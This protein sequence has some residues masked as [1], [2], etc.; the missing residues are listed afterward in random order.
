MSSLQARPPPAQ[1]FASK[2]LLSN[3]E[4]GSAST[5]ALVHRTATVKAT[6]LPAVMAEASPSVPART[7]AAAAEVIALRAVPVLDFARSAQAHLC[8][9]V[10]E[11]PPASMT[12]GESTAVGR[13]PV[14]VNLATWL[15]LFVPAPSMASSSVATASAAS[16]TTSQP[17]L[18]PSSSWPPPSLGLYQ[19]LTNS[20]KL[21]ERPISRSACAEGEHAQQGIESMHVEIDSTAAAGLARA[22]DLQLPQHWRVR[23]V[24]VVHACVVTLLPRK[25]CLSLLAFVLFTIAANFEFIA[26][27]H[28][29]GII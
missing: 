29:H 17:V 28:K 13:I 4:N 21:P 2:A 25:F 26:T 23:C 7:A 6:V 12:A 3:G 15:S 20:S 11:A 8:L 18:L 5:V 19:W 27:V 24:L 10:T 1:V 22:D 14:L 16:L 9:W